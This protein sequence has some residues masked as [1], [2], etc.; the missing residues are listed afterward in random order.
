MFPLAA[1]AIS[2]GTIAAI[3]AAVGGVVFLP[4]I[5]VVVIILLLK[6]TSTQPGGGPP[7]LTHT[8]VDWGIFTGLLQAVQSNDKGKV[9]AEIGYLSK[10][11][12]EAGGVEGLLEEFLYSQLEARLSD[13]SK[14][15]PLLTE[16]AK[17]SGVSA[18]QL[19]DVMEGKDTGQ[20]AAPAATQPAVASAVKAGLLLL[21]ALVFGS[22]A[23]A[24]P[25][26]RGPERFEP[27][28]VQ[29][30]VD[31]PTFRL[32]MT[33]RSDIVA[34]ASCPGCNLQPVAPS[35]GAVA[36]AAAPSVGWWQC[37]AGRRVVSAPVRW[38]FG[39]R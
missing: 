20:A 15:T 27:V 31:P 24:A 9:L 38:L 37:G 8:P 6:R 29:A 2:G 22:A 14:R 25:P 21:S 26:L 35:C 33:G 32:A 19:L 5:A 3:L 1:L 34:P 12:G 7:N 17:M 4:A 13:P 10:R 36:T 11:A 30:V 18:R 16:M 39:G 28:E 23:S